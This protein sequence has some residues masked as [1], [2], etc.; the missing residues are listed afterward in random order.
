MKFHFTRLTAIAALA[1]VAACADAPAAPS[2]SRGLAP[3]SPNHSVS[4]SSVILNNAGFEGGY[5]GWTFQDVDLGP[6]WN[7]SEGR[8]SVDLNGFNPGSVSQSFST[9]PGVLYTVLFD[10]AGN[11][12]NPQGVK[13]LD[14]SAASDL[15]HYS[16]S[17]SGKSGTNMGWTPQ[18]FSFTATGATTTLMF[19]ST[20]V[21]NGLFPD[22]AQGPAIDNVRI[23]FI[24]PP[25]P[26][27]TTVTFGSGPFVYAGTAFTA[28]A[29]VSPAGAGAATI[30]YSGDCTSSGSSCTATATFPGSD[31]YAASSA[32]A[33]ITIDKAP[34]TTSVTFGSGS[35]VYTGSAF[36]ATASVSP[37]AAGAATIV[38]SG[39][40]TSS[41]STC[42]ATATF[43]GTDGY[44]ASSAT[45]SITIDKAPATTTVTFSSGPFVYTGSAFT[46]TASVSPAGAGA[47]TIAY[48]GDCTNA[49]STCVAT[50]TSAGT[51]GYAASSASA[52]I[53]I[54]KAPTT[55][56]VTFGPGPFVYTGGAFAASASV[57]PAAAGTATISYSDCTNA[58]NTCQATATFVGNNN[59]LPSSKVTG[60]TIAKAPT[61]TS[62]TFG[63]GPF[64]YTGNVVTATASVS[65]V[66]AGAATISYSG[67]CTNAGNTCHA[68]A[69][70]VGSNNFLPSGNG[71]GITIAKAPTT[72]T[73]SFG[74]GPFIYT[75]TAFTA[76]ASVSPA[77]AGAATI[78]YSGDCINAGNTCSATAT[79]A[80][81]SNY[82]T[83]AASTSSIL[84]KLP[85]ATS[86]EQCKKG[87]WQFTTD[88]LG[89]LFKNQGDCVS[90][91]ATKGKNKGDGGN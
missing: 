5:T 62:V 81:N 9:I 3:S 80:G 24:P 28:T 18:T 59:F 31:G 33:S 35:F 50:A 79:Y 46:A 78:S 77:P 44:A 49:G 17:T 66:A 47:P 15:T 83:S 67:D 14:V 48:T 16:F 41:G 54:A 40:C 8:N 20:Y 37:A 55:T 7:A 73:V 90:Y 58:G 43:P 51:G 84:I 52:T 57:S 26:T 1:F 75:G 86:A 88:D 53:T 45:A 10:L 82:L 23:T 89:N 85:V 91:V 19:K 69:T 39:D 74:A 60:I 71:T 13:T 38:Y 34:T 72:T 30:V 2:P 21:G 61:T 70:F 42:T 12:G 65:P 36:T 87:G 6:F 22:A 76:T 27:T 25:T 29:S 4:P 56:S 63:P 68:T 32:S 11:P 64:V